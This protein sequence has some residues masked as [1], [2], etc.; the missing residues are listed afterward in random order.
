MTE[1]K[2]SIA[3]D[4]FAIDMV[5]MENPIVSQT[6]LQK[7]DVV[8]ILSSQLEAIVVDPDWKPGEVKV[9]LKSTNTVKAVRSTDVK[10]MAG[11]NIPVARDRSQSR[12]S[13]ARRASAVLRDRATAN[14]LKARIRV[15]VTSRNF[16]LGI[17]LV[18]LVDALFILADK[19]TYTDDDNCEGFPLQLVN[20]VTWVA[21]S[22]YSAEIIL[23]VYGC[24]FRVFARDVWNWFDVLIVVIS[25]A[26]ALESAA[27]VFVLGRVSRFLKGARLFRA[28]RLTRVC[29]KCHF[30]CDIC[31]NMC[32]HV[33]SVNKS[34]YIDQDRNFDLDLTYIEDD[35]IAMGV[36]AYSTWREPLIQFYRNPISEV[37]RFFN[38]THPA[39]YR[40]YNACPELPYPENPFYGQG[41]KPNSRL[42]CLGFLTSSTSSVCMRVRLRAI[43]RPPPDP[44]PHASQYGRLRSVSYRCTR[45][46]QPGR[47][48]RDRCP[49]QGRQRAY[50][51]LV[52][53]LAHLSSQMAA[54]ESVG[55]FR[56]GAHKQ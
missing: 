19:C 25:F 28:V 34:R 43:S 22:I 30:V 41:N 36:P 40:I 27:N 32:Q 18:I 24:G 44:R 9:R 38:E 14:T 42:R 16:Q 23:K 53:R 31:S 10:I 17:L 51:I 5:E 15:V 26:L 11:E 50:G 54:R 39:H 29:C 3:K 21:L 35:L 48:K 49:L 37:A 46:R 7:D 45:F 20:T 2:F 4:E 8:R 55:V 52:L 47:Q 56:E 13:H 6:V 1:D 33:V 12:N